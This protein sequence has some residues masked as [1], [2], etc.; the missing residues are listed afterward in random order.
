MKR[1]IVK[2]LLALGVA[3]IAGFAFAGQVRTVQPGGLEAIQR[4]IDDV[5]ASGGGTVR[6]PRGTW[7]TKPL[8]LKSNITL[9][10]DEGAL[11]LG[12]TNIADYARA[13][14]VCPAL[15]SAQDATNVTVIGRGA[16]FDGRGDGFYERYASGADQPKRTPMMM[17]FA[18]CRQLHLEGFTYRR[19]GSWGIHLMNC[20]GVHVKGLT[21]FN[22]FN[23]CNDGIDI[24]SRNVL[25]EDCDIDADDDSLCFKAESDKTFIIDNVTVRNCRLATTCNFIKFGTGSYKEW[26][27][28]LIENCTLHRASVAHRFRWDKR[29]IP[30]V[31]APISGLA[32]LALEL[33]DGGRMQNVTIRNITMEDGV[34]TPLFIR[35]ARRHPNA[36]GGGSFFK[37]VL[38]ENVKMLKPAESRIASS[39]TGV[40]GMRLSGVTVR[41]CAFLFPGGGTAAEA[42]D[43]N[44]PEVEKGYPEYFGFG[45]KALPAYGLYLRHVDG[46]K[47]ENV[48]LRLASPDRRLAIVYVDPVNIPHVQAYLEELARP[49]LPPGAQTN[50]ENAVFARFVKADEAAD[51]AWCGLAGRAAYDA[52]RAAM[53]QTWGQAMGGLDELARTPL[54]PRVTK[55]TD[56]KG[57][58]VEKVLFESR[59]GCY[60]SALLWLPDPARF[61]PPYRAIVIP[62]GH[63]QPGKGEP[64][65]Q[66][67]GLMAA[68]AGFAAFCYDPIGQGERCQG[69][70]EGCCL[71]HD[72]YG[73]LAE[74]LGQSCARQRIWDGMRAIDYLMS[75]DDICKDGVGCM[76]NSG[77]GTM[78]AFLAAT[79]PRVVAA[80]PSCYITSLRELARTVGPQDAEQFTFGQLKFGLNHTG[81]VMMGNNAVCLQCTFA[82]FFSYKG[83]CETFKMVQASAKAAGLDPA[84][85]ALSDAA[86]PH[87]WKESARVSSIRWM[88]RWLAGDAATPPTDVAADRKLNEGFDPKKVDCGF[89]PKGDWVTPTGNVRDL[90]GFRSIFDLLKDDWEVVKKVRPKRSREEL[91]QVV[92]ARAGIRPLEKIGHTVREMSRTPLAGGVTA[93]RELY[94]FDN[95]MSVPAVTFLPP[96]KP[97]GGVLVVDD[98]NRR[99]HPY[100]VD[101]V[102]ASG[103]TITVADLAGTG[104]T[105]GGLHTRNA[106]MGNKAGDEETATLLHFL[107]ES[108]VGVRAEETLV[109]AAALKSRAGGVTPDVVVNGRSAVAVAHARGVRPD[110]VA[111]IECHRS[112]PS[113]EKAIET[114]AS[115]SYAS[116]VHGALLDYDWTDL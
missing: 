73:T 115:I 109:L 89:P 30:G 55:T 81:L 36:D 45:M 4:A 54:R 17:K 103:R 94:Q 64:L 63:S 58:R 40:P 34:G 27:N 79:D 49:I 95:G 87:G 1:V 22:H 91:A 78:T 96:T 80:C 56:G 84:R 112:P 69:P 59:P 42:A 100:R 71:S 47:L 108:L 111:E 116:I 19:S 51:A 39:I 104:E 62:C 11:V 90:P 5:A 61:T 75:R 38:V 52:H 86:G 93:I 68:E 9:A 113:W 2:K 88:K 76:G 37:N 57:H 41:N 70:H 106:W 18:R 13:D 83:S 32:G 44:I 98:R 29:K 24:E 46:V 28:I 12:S 16:T 20:D 82:D 77:G 110:L 10:L 97:T 43:H 65:Y 107:G 101:A 50:D 3:G 8:F 25:I 114:S 7:E 92:A 35:L 15:V 14:G 53:R 60:V 31:K 67:G 102:L 33:V 105:G 26:R 66:R 23:Q 21:C 6:V 85:Y 74:L 72:R 99:I 48:S